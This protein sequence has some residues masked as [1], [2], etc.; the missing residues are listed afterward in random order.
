MIQVDKKALYIKKG[1]ETGRDIVQSY[2]TPI[3]IIDNQKIITSNK[4]YSRTTSTHKSHI[5][6]KVYKGYQIIEIPHKTLKEII[7]SEGVDIGM[8]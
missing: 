4:K 2:S 7:I 8:M 3:A 6:N 5:I 1:Y